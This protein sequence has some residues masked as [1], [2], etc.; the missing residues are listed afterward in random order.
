MLSAD[1]KE[2]K[3]L[4]ANKEPEKLKSRPSLMKRLFRTGSSASDKGKQKPYP[5]PKS[6][7]AAPTDVNVAQTSKQKSE[8]V[9]LTD[10]DVAQSSKQ[11]TSQ[12]ERTSSETDAKVKMRT[13]PVVKPDVRPKSRKL[14]TTSV[15]SK[16]IETKKPIWK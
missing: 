15:D 12:R 11:K 8:Q 16:K 5:K 6:E 14:S 1:V 4:V 7:Q 3:E 9:T 2:I 10:V 13:A